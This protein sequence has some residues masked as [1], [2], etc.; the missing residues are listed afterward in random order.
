MVK[1]VNFL[2]S[3]QRL[4]LWTQG[5]NAVHPKRLGVWTQRTKCQPITPSRTRC[6][7]G[8]AYNGSE[9]SAFVFPDWFLP[10]SFFE[11]SAPV[12]AKYVLEWLDEEIGDLWKNLD[13]GTRTWVFVDQQIWNWDEMAP[14]G[15]MGAHIQTGESPPWLMIMFKPLLAPKSGLQIPKCPTNV[16]KHT[17]HLQYHPILRTKISYWR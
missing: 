8:L 4:G 11:I 9:V 2:C 15:S 10:Y 7:N 12:Y 16:S 13:L 6:S 3:P 14:Y 5:S 17:S 1:H